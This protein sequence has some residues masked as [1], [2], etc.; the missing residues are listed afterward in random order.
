[1]PIARSILIII[2]T[3]M[4]STKSPEILSPRSTLIQTKTKEKKRK[5]ASTTVLPLEGEMN[6]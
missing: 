3:E 1:M 5:K 4:Y 2:Q 6:I